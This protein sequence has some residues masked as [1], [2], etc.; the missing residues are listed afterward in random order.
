[1]IYELLRCAPAILQIFG[2]R[3]AHFIRV[4]YFLIFVRV[5]NQKIFSCKHESNWSLALWGIYMIYELLRCAPAILQIFGKRPTHF[6]RVAFF[7]IFVSE[8]IHCIND[9][10]IAPLRSRNSTNIRKTPHSF[11]SR[12][13]FSHIC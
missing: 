1:M 5:K 12:C 13:L 10:R 6:I 9:I 2:N 11:H 8:M 7:L 4:A 3:P